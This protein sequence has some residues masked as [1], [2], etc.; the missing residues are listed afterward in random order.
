MDRHFLESR[1]QTFK[2]TRKLNDAIEIEIVMFH[3]KK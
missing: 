2:K 3:A 1:R